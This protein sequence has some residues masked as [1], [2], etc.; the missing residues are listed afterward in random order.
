MIPHH[1]SSFLSFFQNFW[2]GMDGHS[3]FRESQKVWLGGTLKPIQCHLPLSQDALNPFQPSLDT[4]RD[5]TSPAPS[6]CGIF[7]MEKW[8]LRTNQAVVR[9]N[10]WKHCWNPEPCILL[11][12]LSDIFQICILAIFWI[13]SLGLPQS[14]LLQVV[15]EWGWNIYW[16]GALNLVCL[17]HSLL[18]H[19][20]LLG[21]SNYSQK[22][23]RVHLCKEWVG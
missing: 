2:E 3:N 6:L 5:G 20:I 21:F 16:W 4:S 15:L 17:F 19:G 13:V 1:A 7:F 23:S 10:A 12:I 14:V 8:T 18:A 9:A 22:V 11:P